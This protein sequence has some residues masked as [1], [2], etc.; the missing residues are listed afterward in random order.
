MSVGIVFIGLAIFLVPGGFV[1]SIA[2]GLI[3]GETAHANPNGFCL[4]FD[5]KRPL[6]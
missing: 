5:L 4:R 1:R 3:L 6:V 2:I